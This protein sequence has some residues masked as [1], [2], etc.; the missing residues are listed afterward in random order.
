VSGE[1]FGDIGQ[2]TGR[3]R[4]KP[5]WQGT[6]ECEFT[7]HE[8]LPKSPEM[9]KSTARRDRLPKLK[10]YKP[11]ALLVLNSRIFAFISQLTGFICENLR[12]ICF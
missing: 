2:M 7:G 9:P 1:V 5:V 6:G 8:E 12:L 10:N 11:S 3:P 4:V